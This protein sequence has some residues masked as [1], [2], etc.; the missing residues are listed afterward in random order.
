MNV[1]EAA[2]RVRAYGGHFLL[3]GLLTLVAA[4]LLTG[5][6]RVVDRL[7][8]QGLR[9][10][11]AAAPVAQRDLLYTAPEDVVPQQGPH[12]RL[13]A[14]R[15]TQLEAAMPPAVRDAVGQRW[16]VAQTALARL[17]GPALDPGKGLIDLTARTVSGVRDAAT[18]VDGRWPTD[19][20]PGDDEA[21]ELALAEPVAAQLGL[22]VGDRLRLTPPTRPVSTPPASPVA[23]V[24]VFRPNDPADGVWASLPSAL[25]LAEPEG[26]GEPFLT[27]GVTGE[28]GFEALANRG[29]DV[30]FAWRYRVDPQRLDPRRLDGTIEGL[31][32]M[33]RT[34]PSGLTFTQGLDIPL[35]QFAASLR[36]ARTLLAVIVAGMLATLAGLA[37]LAAGLAVRRRRAEFVLLR[38]RGGAARTVVARGLAESLLVLP[39]A[40]A[41]GWYLGGRLPGAG[42]ADALAALPAAAAAT[43]VL[44]L[45]VLV[46]QRAGGGRRDLGSR[47][48]A[49]RL[50]AE[51]TLLLLAGVGAFLLRRRGLGTGGAVDPLLVSVPVLLAIAAAVLALRLYPWPLRL[52][53]RVAARAR[54]SV[55]FLGTARAGRAG[56]GAPLVVVVLAV[57]TAAFCGVVAAG[58]EASRD[59]AATRA[60]PGDALV[61]GMRFAPDTATELAAL[62]GVG[63]VAPVLAEPRQPVLADAAGR[64]TDIRNVHV[65][66]VDGA[67]LADVARRAG[68]EVPVPPALAR[69]ATPSTTAGAGTAG[70]AV[71]RTAG[72]AAPGGPGGGGGQPLPALVSPALA[73]DL[74]DVGLDAAAGRPAFVDVQ[75]NRLPLRVAATV[76]GFPLVD[77]DTERFVVL[78][79]PDV[80]G[81]P[82]PLAPTGF[83]LAADPP[84][85]DAA[86]AA[87]IDEAALY[88][89]AEEGQRRYQRL[90]AVTGGEPPLPPQVSTWSAHRAQLGGAGVN[91]VLVFGFAT[92]AAGG[93]ALGLLALAFVV[94][95]GAR[96]R[97]QAL[98]RLRTMG[99]SRRQWRGLVLVELAP[100]VLVSVLTGALVGAL[101]PVLLTPVLG[102][103]AFT[104]GA[105]V[106]VRFEPGLVAAGLGLAVLALGF[107]IAV[108]TLNNR[109]L[110]LGEVLRLGEES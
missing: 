60:V 66:L 53:S 85:A 72:T 15:L 75:G 76:E 37:V 16:Y 40:A 78:P 98:S 50:T 101:L 82:H 90:G 103:G 52:A 49:G 22:R 58:I 110:R 74:A 97:G 43:L 105:P 44:P 14:A 65:L 42:P 47:S 12:A 6:P 35:R 69:G 32:A 41:L 7:G 19:A 45:A 27:A 48:P 95:A 23:V 4:L 34:R 21:V 33:D 70:P 31:A 24:G 77:R 87:R 100:L 79:W 46:A 71:P 57:A 84:A 20:A 39:A 63:A 88:R 73:A 51:L 5:V 3:L 68:V 11:V 109:R 1:A 61:T 30:G 38:A 17:R 80:S 96:D 91:G 2:R 9:E 10:Q 67:G 13:A 26:D 104:G 86:R 99:L 92:G 81:G 25:R 59:R 18:L 55:A 93:A 56:V 108:E 8:G 64:S 107:A 28:G 106:P 83:V 102:L 62:A 94:L 54:G 36:A 29:W 89:I